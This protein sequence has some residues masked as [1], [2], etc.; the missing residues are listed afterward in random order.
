MLTRR[1]VPQRHAQEASS[2]ANIA[3][4]FGQFNCVDTQTPLAREAALVAAAS[5]ARSRISVNVSAGQR[6][7]RLHATRR[8]CWSGVQTAAVGAQAMRLTAAY[9]KRGQS[10]NASAIHCVSPSPALLRGSARTGLSRSTAVEPH[11]KVVRIWSE[12]QLN[13]HSRLWSAAARQIKTGW[14]ERGAGA[15][16]EHGSRQ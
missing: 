13:N 1:R 6:Q 12:S 10:N 11:R 14:S 8:R 3:R 9:A 4:V 15:V 2:P 5:T 16:S 7:Q